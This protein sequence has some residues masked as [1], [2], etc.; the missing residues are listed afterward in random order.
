MDASYLTALDKINTGSFIDLV[1]VQRNV[2]CLV[3][4]K[5]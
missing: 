2:H 1:D 5:L 4:V 3:C